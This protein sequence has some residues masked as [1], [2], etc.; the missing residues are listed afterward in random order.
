VDV[1]VP[2]RGKPPELDELRARL[3][4]IAVQPADTV[5]VV[6]N[7]PG[8]VAPEDAG[9]E[10]VRV[11]RAPERAAPGYARN[12]GVAHGSADWL[13]FLDADV[14]PRE[15]LLARY[16]E[17]PPG[18]R[19]ALLAGGIRDEPVPPG[20]PATARYAYLRQFMSQDDTLGRGRWGFP[21]T[22]NVA[23]RRA[24]FEELGG[25]RDDIRGGEDADL[26]FRLRAAGWELE[27]R[28][29]AAVVHRNRHTIR[30]FVRQKLTH[31]SGLAWVQR[32]Y[33]GAAVPHRLPGLLW[34]GVRTAGPRL[35]RAARTRDRDEA[36]WALLEPLEIVVHELGRWLPNERPVRGVG[37]RAGRG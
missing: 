25:F 19:T 18:E 35:A 30:G 8:R 36:L 20:G 34:W 9:D 3:R 33:P 17:P 31:G 21:K 27:R 4:R 5:V 28:E 24:A 1:V 26:T 7:T 32:E 12:R 15:D 10:R 22:A 23:L 6:D 37:R 16:F 13:V 2:F 14:V 11:I 29:E